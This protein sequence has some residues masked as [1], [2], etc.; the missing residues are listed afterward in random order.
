M[1]GKAEQK[2]EEIYDARLALMNRDYRIDDWTDRSED[3]SES[4]RTD[5]Y[6]YGRK[7]TGILARNNIISQQSR[8]IEV[9]S[10]PGT[11]VI[12]FAWNISHVTAVEPAQGMR[13][14]I[15]LN[16]DQAG[17]ENYDTIP[18]IWQEVD[19]SRLSKSYDLVIS[20]TV[21]WMFRDI[22]DQIR[23]MEE[24][25]SGYCCLCGGIDTR[26]HTSDD[27][28][29]KVVGKKP[30]PVF[31]EYPLIY[32][33]LFENG[34]Y[35]EVRIIEHFSLRNP[36]NMVKMHSVFFPL[37][38]TMTEEK[39]EIIQKHV[40]NNLQDGMYMMKFKTAVL[41]WKAR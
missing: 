21:I 13:D 9:G 12:P 18:S 3:Y 1:T 2:W 29:K 34:I 14:Q 5:N 10:G 8:M 19:I 22:M 30:K 36:E 20:S 33:I 23:R 26:T 6:Q 37:F 16:A 31:P 17:I 39:K 41:W 24:V 32:N 27:L 38:T 15:H 7:V 35:P 40:M 11:F 25:S 28:W 4:R